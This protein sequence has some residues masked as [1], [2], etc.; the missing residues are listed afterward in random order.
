MIQHI[1]EDNRG[2]HK[3]KDLFSP[4]NNSAPPPPHQHSSPSQAG[5]EMA[6]RRGREFW[7][8]IDPWAIH[9]LKA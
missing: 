7:Y 2:P 1:N 5:A 6:A 9:S 8:K 4:F 3:V